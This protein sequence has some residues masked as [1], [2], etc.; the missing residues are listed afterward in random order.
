M[1][2]IA[3]TNNIPS[4]KSIICFFEYLE[5]TC[6]TWSNRNSL[7]WNASLLL[8]SRMCFTIGHWMTIQV[9]K[10][11]TQI[12]LEW[13]QFRGIKLPLTIH[14][15]SSYESNLNLPKLTR[16]YPKITPMQWRQLK[17]IKIDLNSTK[18]TPMYWRQLEIHQGWLR[19]P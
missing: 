9:L 10:R 5:L 16:I 13:L 2:S 6:V 3:M 11:E 8:F 15:L 7:Q 14:H 4:R 1:T 17:F 18:I 12:T 19:F